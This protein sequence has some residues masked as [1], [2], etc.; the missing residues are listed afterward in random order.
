MLISCP[1]SYTKAEARQ[2]RT[3]LEWS[4]PRD[5]IVSMRLNQSLT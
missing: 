4:Y 2:H 3:T 1:N 5:A